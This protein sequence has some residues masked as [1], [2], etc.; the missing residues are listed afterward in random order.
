MAA[1]T[2]KKP[3]KSEIRQVSVPLSWTG[4][5]DCPVLTVTNMMSQFDGDLF[6][7][8]FG[9][10]NPPV[11]MGTPQQVKQQAESVKAIRVSTVS[12]ISLTENQLEKTI[13]TLQINLKRYRKFKKMAEAQS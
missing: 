13:K 12:R 3:E 5:E 11:L 2:G 6:V 10:N 1:S 4:V 8:S 9:F 7:L